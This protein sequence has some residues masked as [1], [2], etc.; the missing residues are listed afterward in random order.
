MSLLGF[1]QVSRGN[2]VELDWK[3]DGDVEKLGRGLCRRTAAMMTST[4]GRMAP[5]KAI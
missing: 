1:A 2:A 5:P 3:M 4:L